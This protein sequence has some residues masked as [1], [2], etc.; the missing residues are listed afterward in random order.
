MFETGLWTIVAPVSRHE[1]DV[2]R[3]QPDPVLE[4]D[5]RREE[6]DR[7][8]VLGQRPAVHPLAGQGLH[9]RLEH[10]DVDREVELVRERGRAGQHVVGAALR[11]GRRRADR[12]ALVGAVEPLDRARA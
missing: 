12:D 1:L 3:R 4:R 5:P 2:A 6:A 11:P 7:L 8:H 9:A 10:V